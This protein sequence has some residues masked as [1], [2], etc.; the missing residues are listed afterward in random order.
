MID[1]MERGQGRGVLMAG[2]HPAREM[3]A[4]ICDDTDMGFQGLRGQCT[5]SDSIQF[6]FLLCSN[7]LPPS[8]LV[9]RSQRSH[10]T[11]E[12]FDNAETSGWY[13][14]TKSQTKDNV[15]ERT[16]NLR[17]DISTT[18]SQKN[19]DIV[20]ERCIFF[21]IP[22]SHTQPRQT[23]QPFNN[24]I[25]PSRPIPNP[26]TPLRRCQHQRPKR[27]ERPTPRPLT[28][29]TSTACFPC[30]SS[31]SSSCSPWWFLGQGSLDTASLVGTGPRFDR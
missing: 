9:P 11:F 29:R 16:K 25:G 1:D 14:H 12:F 27:L 18:A 23:H 17:L 22:N 31:P 28:S 4:T 19:C 20:F 15:R 13:E 3:T 8:C 10:E 6:S 5:S 21:H 2:C 30:A 24:A 26:N 7:R